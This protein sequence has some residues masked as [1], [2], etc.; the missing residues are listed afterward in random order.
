MKLESRRREYLKKG[1][2]R[3][4]LKE[5][6]FDQFEIWMKQALE[7]GIPDATAMSLATVD[8]NGQ[9]SQRT[10]LLKNILDYQFVFFTNL[11]SKKAKD[12]NN[13]PNV[14]LLF[15]WLT[16]ER[17]I[18]IQGKATHLSKSESLKY[19]LSRPYESQLSAWASNQSEKVSSRKFLEQQFA[20][21]KNKFQ[22]GEVPLPDFWGGFKIKPSLFEFWQGRGKRLH[23]R[24]QYQINDSNQK[25][26]WVIERLAP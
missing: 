25:Q 18:K 21:M 23:D 20:S 16:L 3:E 9:P 1:L 15:S 10:V 11:N 6:P 12:I 7:Q 19:F 24:F 8:D 4:S 13:N 2:T 22:K 26:Q 14:S 5:N 17:Q